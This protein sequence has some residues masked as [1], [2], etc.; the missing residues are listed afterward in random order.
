MRLLVINTI[1]HPISHSFQVIADYW[2]CALLCVTVSYCTFM[3]L[4]NIVS[5]RLDFLLRIND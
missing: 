4:Y 3:I 2:S 1:L 5:G